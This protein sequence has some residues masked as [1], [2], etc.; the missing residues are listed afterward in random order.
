[1]HLRREQHTV[2]QE[3]EEQLA[4]TSHKM[5][6][7]LASCKCS[8]YSIFQQSK[9]SHLPIGFTWYFLLRDLLE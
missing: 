7:L 6:K 2:A 3:E 9:S 1:M 8:F 4:D 5:A